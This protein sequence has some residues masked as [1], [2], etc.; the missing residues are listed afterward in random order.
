MVLALEELRVRLGE[1][2]KEADC[3]DTVW[4]VLEAPRAQGPTG[5]STC[6]T[7]WL[8]SQTLKASERHEIFFISAVH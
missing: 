6:S 8:C 5:M 4:P 3:G 7:M 2:A 1:V